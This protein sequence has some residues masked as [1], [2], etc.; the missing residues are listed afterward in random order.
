MR[1]ADAAE[2]K[3]TRENPRCKPNQSSEQAGI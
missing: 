2:E 3:E 1:C